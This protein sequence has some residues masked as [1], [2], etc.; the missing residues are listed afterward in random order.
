MSIYTFVSIVM[1]VAAH[2]YFFYNIYCLFKE[3]QEIT[4][5]LNEIN[6]IIFSTNQM[7]EKLI[8]RKGD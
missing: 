4:K 6:K 2:L 8:K 3:R 1:F 5:K 7:L